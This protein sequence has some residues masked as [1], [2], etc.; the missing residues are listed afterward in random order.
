MLREICR[1]LLFLYF[2]IVN[3]TEFINLKNVPKEGALIIYSNHTSN[4]DPFVIG[5]P[6]KRMVYFMAKQELFN[7]KIMEKFF[8]AL[9]AFP[10]KRGTG[11][12]SAIKN[13]LGKLKIGGI[14]CMFP[15]G[16]RRKAGKV[17]EVKPGIAMFAIKARCPVLPVA[18]I[19][20]PK[21][22]SKL[23]IVYGKPFDLSKYYDKKLSTDDYISISE[24]L[25]KETEKILEG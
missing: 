1:V 23:K 9:G 13:S 4:A 18:V 22:L 11:D 8:T 24:M 17:S 16:T 20:K 19:G 15:E 3:R 7:I 5:C 6:I 12:I 2:K 10:V 21:F 25:M 14:L